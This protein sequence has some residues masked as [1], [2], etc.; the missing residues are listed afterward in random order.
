MMRQF[1]ANDPGRKAAFYLSRIGF[2]LY[3]LGN[4][5]WYWVRNTLAGRV[6][7]FLILPLMLAYILVIAP[8]STSHP[9][10]ETAR[11]YIPA[12][13]TFRQIADSLEAHRLLHHK[14]L[15]I[16]LG[17]LTGKERNARAGMFDI[18]RGISTWELLNYLEKAPNAQIKVTIPEGI[19]A[20]RM[21][22]IFQRKLGID[23]TRFMSL[24]YDSAFARE[25]TG[26]TIENLEGYLFPETYFFEWKMPPEQIIRHMVSRTLE[27]FQSPAARRRLRELGW[28][29]HQVLTLASIIEGEAMVDSERV[30]ISSLYHN[31]LRLGWPLQA[32]PTIQF[33]VPG[34]PRRLLKKDLEIDSPY[35]TYKYPGLPPGPINNPGKKSILAALYP[36][37]TPYLYMVAVGDGSHKF[38]RTLKEHNYWH[39]RFNEIRRRVK[40]RGR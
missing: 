4:L 31:R 12:G 17:K 40:R 34:P 16:W 5:I 28:T 14:R 36:A 18:P 21:A 19:L 33:I 1:Q 27:L 20:R 37:N 10:G 24:V 32:D 26:E 22:G 15:F 38:S 6:T 9:T 2:V 39:A 25:L 29:P 11:L 13:A 7:V 3:L 30:I 35:N 23:S 8:L